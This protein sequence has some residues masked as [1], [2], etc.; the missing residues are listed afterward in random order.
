VEQILA[1]GERAIDELL[2]RVEEETRSC[3]VRDPALR[4]SNKIPAVRHPA[5]SR[6]ADLPTGVNFRTR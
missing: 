6:L 1:R 2:R 4:L 3:D 5:L